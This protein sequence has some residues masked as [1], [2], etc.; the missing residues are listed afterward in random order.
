MRCI[1]CKS[2][3]ETSVSREHIL[4]ESLGNTKH[5]LPKGWVC[6]KCNNYFAREVEKPFLESLYGRC[7]RFEMRVPNKEGRIPSVVGFHAQSQTKVDVFH[8]KEDGSLSIAVADGED[9]AAW[10]ASL[11]RESRG[12]LYVPA[13]TEPTA[14]MTTARFIGKVGLEVLAQRCLEVPG[15]NDEIVDKQE[16]D[17]LRTYARRGSL[18]IL[19]PIHVRHLYAADFLFA[20]DTAGRHEVMH[21]W[22]ILMTP[23]S[24]CFAV[25]AIFGL[26]YAINLGGPEI[27]GYTNWLKHNMNRSPLYPATANA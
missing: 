26:E 20:D 14:D 5:V 23:E 22:T 12:T 1:F 10:V 8:S 9:E 24:E 16:L 3:S 2:P 13:A 4:S 19:W 11:S 27:D 17:A 18:R 25:I 21:E 6:D 7:S 15:G